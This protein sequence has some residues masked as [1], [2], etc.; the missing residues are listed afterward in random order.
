LV[1]AASTSYTAAVSPAQQGGQLSRVA[2]QAYALRYADLA[3]G[4]SFTRAN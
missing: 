4:C 3:G 1:V 2:M